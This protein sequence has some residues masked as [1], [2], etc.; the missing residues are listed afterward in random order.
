MWRRQRQFAVSHLKNFA[1]GKKTLEFHIQQECAFLCEAFREEQGTP[2]DPT[3]MINNAVANVIGSLV[4]GQRFDYSN[5]DFQNLLRM[6][7]ESIRLAGSALV[8]LYDAFPGIC[9]RLP[10]PH[11]TILSNYA[12][13]VTFLRKEI[14][15]HKREWDPF[16]HRDYIDAY[17]GE[18]DKR[19]KDSEAGFSTENLAYCSV[20]LF[21]AGTE[22]LT[23]TLRWALL[24]MTK[25][26]DVQKK[27]QAEIDGVIGPSRPPSMA[28]RVHMPY[29]NAVIH[30]VQRMGNILPLNVP[31]VT[32]KDTTLGGYFL[33][34]GTMVITN[35]SSVMSDPNEWETG[36]QFNPGHFLDS[37]GKFQRREAFLPF[38][39]GKRA[40]LGEQ[41]ARMEL[42]LFFTSLLHKF[43]FS[44]VPGEQPSLE[45]QIGVTLS[46]KPFRI[47]VS[48]H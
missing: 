24:F 35:L 30:E 42:F 37:E 8:Q 41:L 13:I 1:E 43:N 15:K 10:G 21:E 9:R 22:T 47:C 44:T 23:N 11:E 16:D 2:F 19:K 31:R 27:V 20:D 46:P 7:A 40:C 28:D 14:E 38:S 3:V 17:V 26:P 25:Y 4:F 48:G 6:S 36:G 29:T 12:K 33:P 18:I 39:A 32:S 45:A 5:T 34:K